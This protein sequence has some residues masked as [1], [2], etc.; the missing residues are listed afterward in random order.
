MAELFLETDGGYGLDLPD[1]C[2]K[3]GAPATVRKSKTFSW[4]PPWVYLLLLCNLIVF[5]VVALIVTK[6]RRLEVPLC[7]EHKNHWMWRQLLVLGSLLFLLAAGF[8]VMIATT[9]NKGPGGGDDLSGAVCMGWLVLM[10]VWIVAAVIAQV[11]SIRPREITD[12]SITLLGV[13]PEFVRVFDSEWQGRPQLPPDDLARE[14]WNE[15]S[16][17]PRRDVPG[18]EDLD[19][20][21][22]PDDRDERR[23]PDTFQEG[24]P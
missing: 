10:V 4:C 15:R 16:R 3:C 1:V 20:I 2:M 8:L 17:R 7:A 23:P 24:T 19:R 18:D 13:S 22:R 6:R 5:A 9:D 14:R 11:T 21:R 12:R